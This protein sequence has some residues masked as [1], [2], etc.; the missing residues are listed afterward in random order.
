MDGKSAWTFFNTPVMKDT[1]LTPV[2]ADA[3][4]I[5]LNPQ[6]GASAYE[7]QSAKGS[8]LPFIY[9]P[10]K[11]G[12]QFGGWYDGSTLYKPNETK[13]SKNVTLTA[14]WLEV[15]LLKFDTDGGS[16]VTGKYYGIYDK[17]LGNLPVSVKAGYTFKGW[18]YDGKEYTSQTVYKFNDSITLKAKW[19]ENTST[20]IENT[21]EDADSI[22]KSISTETK[23]AD[24]NESKEKKVEVES[25]DGNVKSVVE[26]SNGADKADIITTVKT[27]SNDG[28]NAVTKEQIEQAIVIQGKVSDEIKDDVKDHSKVIQIESSAPDA[29]LTVPKD[30]I[31]AASDANSSL[32]IVSEKG[33]IAASD[34]V[35]SN[36]LVEE[37]IT[38]SISEAKDEHI[39]NAQRENIPDGAVVVDVRIMAGDKDLGKSLGGLITISIRYTPAD[40]KIGV[41][42]HIDDDGNKV[43]MGG[44]YDPIKGEIVFDS[45]HCSLY[46]VVDED[47]S[48][49]GLSNATIFVGIAVAVVAAIAVAIM[50]YVRKR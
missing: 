25:K 38:I 1:V 29:S 23:A 26:I 35:L 44:I 16:P 4:T 20:T 43:R 12:Y 31:K 42:Y 15:S 37:E 30:A 41:A 17:P 46:M 47:P 18:Y 27:D 48:K 33:S 21:K 50:L 22:I 5:K 8:E 2:Y 39:N 19:A 3:V 36:M 49:S 9:D 14:K 34:T 11:D 40:G 10:S 7:I 45:T 24:G 6:N 28:N 32:R 13:V